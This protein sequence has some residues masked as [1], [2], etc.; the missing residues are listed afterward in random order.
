MSHPFSLTGCFAATTVLLCLSACGGGGSAPPP[1]MTLGADAS[2]APAR[3]SFNMSWTSTNAD[4]CIAG[5]DWYGDLA[6]DGTQAVQVVRRGGN[7]YTL[8][9]KGGGG[10]ISKSVA[11]SGTPSPSEYDGDYA[12]V[13]GDAVGSGLS[14]R[15][16]GGRVALTVPCCGNGNVDVD[17]NISFQTVGTSASAAFTGLI[18]IADP[19][20]SVGGNGSYTAAAG[21][22]NWSA[23]RFTSSSMLFLPD[24]GPVA[25]AIDY[26]GLP[27]IQGD[28]ALV[29]GSDGTYPFQ[30]HNYLLY[31]GG[32]YWCMWSE[33][34][35]EDQPGTHVRYATSSD[36]LHW[37]PSRILVGPTTDGYSGLARGFWVR[38]GQLLALVAHFKGTGAFGVNK[39]LSLQAYVYNDS[40][41]SWD[42]PQLVQAGQ[43][44]NFPPMLL[45]SGDW[46]FAARDERVNNSVLIGGT[47][48]LSTWRKVPLTPYTAPDNFRPDEPVWTSFDNGNLVVMFRDNGGSGRLFRSLSIDNGQT[49]TTPARSNFPDSGSKF[50]TFRTS[51][52]YWVMVSNANPNVVRS[53]LLL[54]TSADGRIYTRMAQLDIPGS[55]GS[56]T[57][58]YPHVIEQDGYLLIALSRNKAQIEVF[59]VPLQALDALRAAP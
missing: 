29:N 45:P 13:Y 3:S 22:G 35:G 58:Q 44:N 34:P 21:S 51:A 32:Q 18:Q 52:G 16:A 17:G 6:T 33:G 2:T 20:T 23:Q 42:G 11:V 56:N 8:T 28:S 53:Q 14:F 50:F 5:G 43:I 25:N 26:D 31:Y 24:V 41:G 48:D 27:R 37:N 36:G 39:D 57:L 40:A 55:G 38:N 15:A 19:N 30:L 1:T 9:C 7:T 47:Q 12:G 10:S 4:T 46:M 49:W 59:R 54:S